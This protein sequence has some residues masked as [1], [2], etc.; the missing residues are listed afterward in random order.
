MS[1]SEKTTRRDLVLRLSLTGGALAL[2][3]LGVAG[4]AGAATSTALT[5]DS[6]QAL[7][8]L[9]ADNQKAKTLGSL[10]T[11]V[12]V[13]PHIVKA[14]LAIGGQSGQGALLLPTGAEPS[15]FYKITAASFGLQIGAQSFCYVLFLMN[16][17]AM[18]YLEEADGWSIGVGP[19]IAVLDK[20]AAANLDTSTLRED[21]Y[22]IAFGQ[23]G[24]MAGIT[25]D[26]SRIARIHPKP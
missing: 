23:K 2:G 19:T 4:T 18:T 24:L 25:L 10:A 20:G 3:N 16:Q 12:L 7:S 8:R 26:G 17:K 11:G 14:G 15:H 5:A 13:F 22:A 6:R 21:V 9:Y 1:T